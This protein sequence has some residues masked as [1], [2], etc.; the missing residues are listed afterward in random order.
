MLEGAN[1]SRQDC[2]TSV[3]LRYPLDLKDV[4]GDDVQVKT[5]RMLKET[6][7]QQYGVD[8]TR[9]LMLEEW[10]RMAVDS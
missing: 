5:F 7:T 9:R 8:R 1:F 2:L 3:G 10:D 6:E 4:Y